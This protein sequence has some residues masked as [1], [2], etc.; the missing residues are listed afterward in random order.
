MDISPYGH[1]DRYAGHV[2]KDQAARRQWLD[3]AHD[4]KGGL[5]ISQVGD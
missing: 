5:A 1:L 4:A 3:G 2:C